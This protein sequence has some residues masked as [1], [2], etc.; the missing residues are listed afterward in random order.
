MVN[1][2]NDLMLVLFPISDGLKS[3]KRIIF[4][5]VSHIRDIVL[6]RLNVIPV[7]TE[8]FFFRNSVL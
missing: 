5:F 3:K 8:Y 7:C 2:E 6:F 4:Q 1:D